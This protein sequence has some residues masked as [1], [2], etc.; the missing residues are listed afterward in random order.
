M[1]K[2]RLLRRMAGLVAAALFVC[3]CNLGREAPTHTFAIWNYSSTDYFV[4]VTA[5]AGNHPY[6]V[7]PAH[8]IVYATLASS[9]PREAEVYDA[10]CTTRVASVTFPD[11]VLDLVIDAT[12][13]ISVPDKPKGDPT[14]ADPSISR[15][16]PTTSACDQFMQTRR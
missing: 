7:A 3:G 10:T 15:R 14:S 13:A 1:F 4:A 2:L 6:F 5:S 9:L 8:S 12:G 11:G 16:A